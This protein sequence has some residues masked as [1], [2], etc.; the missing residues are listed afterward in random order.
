MAK[1]YNAEHAFFIMDRVNN[2]VE[3]ELDAFFYAI[4]DAFFDKA[5]SFRCS[6]KEEQYYFFLITR[7]YG[8]DFENNEDL[9]LELHVFGEM[10]IP[11]CNLLNLEAIESDF[12][13]IYK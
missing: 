13:N 2:L 10:K 11:F 12:V 3:Q 8:I 9:E 1:R 6:T 4:D 5:G 7:I